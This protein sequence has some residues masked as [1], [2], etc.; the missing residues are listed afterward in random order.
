VTFNAGPVYAT[1]TASD[2]TDSSGTPITLTWNSNTEPCTRSG[3]TGHWGMTEG[4]ASSGVDYVL[5]GTPGTYTY[6][7]QCGVGESTTASAQVTVSFTGAPRPMLTVSNSYPVAGQPFTL[8]WD[9]AGAN[10][11]CSREGGS[12]TDGWGSEGEVLPASGTM[13]VVEPSAGYLSYGLFCGGSFI[14]VDVLPNSTAAPATY[15]PSGQL[16]LPALVIG[17]AV[18][19]NTSVMLSSNFYSNPGGVAQ[20]GGV[21][22]YDP[23]MG[24]LII[25][26][27]SIGT[28]TQYNLAAMAGAL[29]SVGSVS[30]ADT[31]NGS[32]LTIPVVDVLNR[33]VHYNV[34]VTVASI[35]SIAGGMPL[36]ARDQFDPSTGQLIIPVVEYAGLYFTNVTI[37][38]GSIISVGN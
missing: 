14:Y 5:E 19:T 12:V 21:P 34:V 33:A 8:T 18:F 36:K 31:Y 10:G 32:Q 15:H 16:D 24:Q 38:V 1:L 25:P 23:T 28:A 20:L 17:D 3:S 35:V 7:I 9:S 13:R 30:G 6:K 2:P 37:V 29:I 4:G 22:S 27:V 11:T 26:T